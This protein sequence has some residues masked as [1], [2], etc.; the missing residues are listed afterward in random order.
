[1]RRSVAKTVLC[2]VPA[3]VAGT[4]VL[5]GC[6]D[7]PNQ[8]YSPATGT[9]FNNGATDGA[10]GV[11]EASLDAGYVSQTALTPC[12]AE[13]QR[14][15][16][17]TM[18]NEPMIPPA[19]FA[20]LDLRGCGARSQA[21]YDNKPCEWPGLAIEDAEKLPTLD[22]TSGQ[23]IGANCQGTAAGSGG[24]GENQS[25]Q[26]G[27]V[28]W[29]DNG[30]VNF[31]YDL[32]THLIDQLDIGI[33]YLGMMAFDGVMQGDPGCSGKPYATPAGQTPPHYTFQIGYPIT[34][35]SNT[36]QI[37][38]GSSNSAAIAELYDGI[39][40]AFY[41][42]AG[43]VW[44][45]CNAASANGCEAD[46]TCL[47]I[48]NDG[49]GTGYFGIRPIATYIQFH[50]TL[51]QPSASIPF[52]MYI[53]YA[54]FV[55]NSTQNM[56]LT[57]N[58]QGPFTD[59][60]IPNAVNPG[61]CIQ[62]LGQ[63]YASY[64]NNC[65]EPYD[66]NALINGVP[67]SQINATNYNKMIGGHTHNL[68]EITF[69]LVG[70]NQNFAL[71]SGSLAT[72]QL[73]G[74]TNLGPYGV[75][76][77]TDLPSDGDLST[78]WYF[79]IRAFGNP[80][81]EITGGANNLWGTALVAR[82][83]QR[84]T[85]IDLASL[86]G[87]L[88]STLSDCMFDPTGAGAP[89]TVPTPQPGH[90]C[91][92]MELMLLPGTQTW[93]TDD[94]AI[95]GY[96]DGAV[97]GAEGSALKPGDHYLSFM[98][99][100]LGVGETFGGGENQAAYGPWW[101]ISVAWVT[102][103]MGKGDI[104]NLPQAAA[105]RRYFFKWFGVAMV[106]YLRA[107]GDLVAQGVAPDP[108]T[109]TPTL[110]AAEPIDMETLFFDNEFGNQFDKFEYI[111]MTTVAG[112]AGNTT[113]ADPNKPY[114]V[115]PMDYE[116][117]TDVRVAN[118]RYSN[119]YKRLDREELALYMALSP[120]KSDPPAAHA[121]YGVNL[122]NMY[123]SSVLAAAAGYNPA[124]ASYECAAARYIAGIPQD[125]PNE[126]AFNNAKTD[127]AGTTLPSWL[128]DPVTGNSVMDLNG[129]MQAE[130]PAGHYQAVA[131]SQGTPLNDAHTLLY[132]YPAAFG[133][134]TIFSQGHS[135]IQ[136]CPPGA[137]DC[138][139]PSQPTSKTSI[140]LEA[141]QAVIP[142][143]LNPWAACTQSTPGTKNTSGCD[144]TDPTYLHQNI[145]T[146]V[147]WMPQ[148]PGVGFPIPANGT[149]NMFVET[150]QLDFTGN[151]ETYTVDYVPYQDVA[152]TGCAY[153]G[154][155][156]NKGYKCQAGACVA[157]DNTIE[158][159]AV[160]AHDFLGNVFVCFDPTTQDVLH[161]RMYTATA[162]ILQWLAAHP[163]DPGSATT[164]TNPSAQNACN[165]IVRYSP[166]DNYPDFITSLTYGVSLA[167]NQGM[168]FGRIVDATLFNPLYET[169]TQ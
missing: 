8:T 167:T 135:A 81:N 46:G 1:M 110:V 108:T 66:P 43:S 157:Q 87:K 10:A 123:G 68:E 107:Y 169:I 25:D 137:T 77:D 93:P 76:Q 58:T 154:G 16:W 122:T 98:T 22:P 36:F 27:N 70:I 2:I 13:I 129:K 20:G 116:Y 3:L 15:R 59:G 51:P 118:Q 89:N 28:Q 151:L 34:K 128:M 24:C 90:V 55:P 143:F 96:L 109:L 139:D 69:N 84:L 111:D 94:P 158:I 14:S 115:T 162:D 164:N 97:F 18:L 73:P 133:G 79:D 159:R 49:T 146:L 125:D 21:D 6:E 163:G 44:P 52:N 153:T 37:D 102:R 17:A 71:S 155:T 33:G 86:V 113:A 134:K 103:I 121:S 38:W 9:L 160:E 150:D 40:K 31:S 106:K 53:D 30:E 65:I 82:E 95:N 61:T 142:S 64:K 12:S 91:T 141:A 88:P 165:L 152:Q 145:Y 75:V 131:T 166:F 136:V 126:P 148:Q 26:C 140:S 156:C 168:G 112:Y 39:A 85:E 4:A 29:G 56:T 35:N 83:F 57:L 63:T 130:D 114:L 74:G 7:G 32:A 47:Y 104:Y 23:Y 62:Q 161:V 41:K 72:P 11:V 50:S 92:G 67:G 45:G 101:D 99:N 144:P 138:S 54:K 127:C 100:P 5:A 147:P 60:N 80:A 119:W 42:N 19:V 120:N 48:G 132:Q 149:S 117:G 78:E 105:D 124:L